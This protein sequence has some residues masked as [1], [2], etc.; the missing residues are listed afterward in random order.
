MAKNPPA[1]AGTALSIPGLGRSPGDGNH[2]PLQYSCLGNPMDRGAW[3]A[4]YS[5]GP[6]LVGHSLPTK[7]H[8]AHSPSRRM[9]QG[10]GTAG[11]QTPRQEGISSFSDPQSWYLVATLPTWAWGFH[12]LLNY[13]QQ[14][15]QVHVRNP[16]LW[17]E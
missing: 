16:S 6:Q 5:M 1:N 2:N 12:L 7:Q 4:T 9:I 13:S 11:G 8:C 17:P 3:W 10:S 14:R 15:T